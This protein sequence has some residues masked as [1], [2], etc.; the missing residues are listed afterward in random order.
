MI[1]V[2]GFKSFLM[3]IVRFLTVIF[4]ILTTLLICLAFL[5]CLELDNEF[6]WLGG[7]NMDGGTVQNGQF[8]LSY[9]LISSTGT[10]L[11]LVGSLVFYKTI[12][13]NSIKFNVFNILVIIGFFLS[14]MNTTFFTKYL[15]FKGY[16]V[17]QFTNEV[18][19]ELIYHKGVLFYAPS[20]AFLLLTYLAFISL[21][22]YSKYSNNNQAP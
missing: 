18:L 11:F 21:I 10:V 22:L 16:E 13:K 8:P 6:Y 4:Y 20:Y 12:Y 15:I 14:W 3:N 2:N 7:G 9:L 19:Q 5:F 1:T 17:D